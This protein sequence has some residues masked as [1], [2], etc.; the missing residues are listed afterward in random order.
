MPP[1]ARAALMAPRPSGP[2]WSTSRERLGSS[3]WWRSPRLRT[4]G[5]QH[6]HQQHAVLAHRGHEAGDAAPDQSGAP[7]A[8]GTSARQP[9]G[10]PA[11]GQTPPRDRP[12]PSPV[13][14][15]AATPSKP[16]QPAR[17]W[18]GPDRETVDERARADH[19]VVSYCRAA[20]STPRGCRH[21]GQQQELAEVTRSDRV[22]VPITAAS[23]WPAPV[24]RSSRGRATR[25]ASTPPRTPTKASGGMRRPSAAP[26]RNSQFRQL[27]REPA[28][29]HQLTHRGHRVGE[30]AGP[31]AAEVAQRRSTARLTSRRTSG[32]AAQQRDGERPS[33]STPPTAF[34]IAKPRC[35][36]SS[37]RRPSRGA[38]QAHD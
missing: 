33:T 38:H 31:Q 14:D 9:Q 5:E 6:Q 34:R 1:T 25:S 11:A 12:H 21:E 19:V 30:D 37:R 22:S 3:A 10:R 7:M 2:V 26:T 17:A 36:G 35:R 32:G 4:G 29:H 20:C 15:G 18:P 23:A 13:R 24:I 27:E 16:H 28:Q 8:T